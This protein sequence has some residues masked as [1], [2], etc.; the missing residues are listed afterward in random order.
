VQQNSANDL[1]G[2]TN[3]E[4][5]KSEISQR[6]SADELDGF[7]TYK[8]S[9]FWELKI[10]D[11][12]DGCSIHKES[13]LERAKS[14]GTAKVAL[15]DKSEIRERIIDDELGGPTTRKGVGLKM[16]NDVGAANDVPEDKPYSMEILFGGM[17]LDCVDN[18]KTVD[19]DEVARTK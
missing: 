9:K 16:S 5:S 12:V 6:D 13:G 10:V 2:C 3:H 1:D 4:S 11:E 14:V 15:G 8:K 19:L 17:R 18:V 7:D